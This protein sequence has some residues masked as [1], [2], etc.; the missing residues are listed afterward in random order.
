M[1]GRYYAYVVIITL[2]L[3]GISFY[4]ERGEGAGEPGVADT[5]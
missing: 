1:K 4:Q 5:R 2:F 3:A